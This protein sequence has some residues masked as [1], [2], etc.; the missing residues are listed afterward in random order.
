MENIWYLKNLDI[1]KKFT[2]ANL[3]CEKI[4]KIKRCGRRE[5]IFGPGE[6]ESVYLI[7]AGRMRLFKKL[8]EDKEL[9]LVVLEAGDIWG[10]IAQKEDSEPEIYA[11]TLDETI[12]Y[13]IKRESF[14][15]LLTK[16]P[17]LSMSVTKLRRF[18][19]SKIEMPLKNLIFRS[20]P[21]RLARLLMLL[22]REYHLRKG[23]H[24]N[25]KLSRKEMAR[26]ICAEVETI[27]QILSD[28][29]RLGIIDIKYNRIK[30]LNQWELKRVASKPVDWDEK[31]RRQKSRSER[32]R[33]STSQFPSELSVEGGGELYYGRDENRRDRLQPR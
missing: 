26:L 18:C 16:R 30:I 1:F 19:L 15:W 33:S 9:T 6:G 31:L 20:V 5:R 17:K 27:N 11:E 7:R 12:L 32:R 4:A 21:S 2:A 22:A 28:C 8:P 10:E 13:V 14:A 25:I 3:R 24:L 29:E 23:R